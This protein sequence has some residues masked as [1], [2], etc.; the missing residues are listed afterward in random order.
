[1]RQ[2]AVGQKCPRCARVPRR[3]QA[4]GKPIHYVKGGGAG[5]VV[6]VVGGFV[7][8]FTRGAIGFGGILLPALLGFGVGRTVSWGAQR[9]THRNFEILAVVLGVIGGI[10]AGGGL[11]V[12]NRPF[13]LLG[14]AA[15]GYFARRGL[16]R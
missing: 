12:V 7:L 16:H 15:A 10:L 13:A 3:A 1:M 6:A 8:G 11:A 5:L 14:V 4:L 9:Q 2:A